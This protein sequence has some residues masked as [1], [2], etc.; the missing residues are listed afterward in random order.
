VGGRESE[1][2]KGIGIPVLSL[3]LLLVELD[4]RAFPSTLS[5]IDWVM[6]EISVGPS[7]G[8][9]LGVVHEVETCCAIDVG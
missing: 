2:N 9:L 7:S 8:V 1:L 4:S 6:I 5:Y 3:H